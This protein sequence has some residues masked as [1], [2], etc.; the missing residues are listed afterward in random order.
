LVT[1]FIGILLIFFRGESNFLVVFIKDL[2][3]FCK[4]GKY[5]LKCILKLT[6]QPKSLLELFIPTSVKQKFDLKF[7]SSSPCSSEGIN[8][9]WPTGREVI[10]LCFVTIGNADSKL[11]IDALIILTPACSIIG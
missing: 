10:F 2:Q 7:Y 3:T 1:L 6:P 4:H 8:A 5:F 9:A 11:D